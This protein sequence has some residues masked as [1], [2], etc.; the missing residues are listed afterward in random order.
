[1]FLVHNIAMNLAAPLE[2]ENDI[3]SG[4]IMWIN[5]YQQPLVFAIVGI[6]VTAIPVIGDATFGSDLKPSGGDA[7]RWVRNTPLAMGGLRK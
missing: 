3:T 6:L 1:M 7:L 4:L 5:I 2:H